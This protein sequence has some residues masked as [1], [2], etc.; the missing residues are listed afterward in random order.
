M[1][2]IIKSGVVKIKQHL[3]I[4]ING[5]KKLLQNDKVWTIIDLLK[6]LQLKQEGRI[7]EVNHTIIQQ[8]EYSEI[9]LKQGDEVEIIQFM[10]GGS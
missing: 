9:V 4:I 8:Q 5:E 3:N 7:I 1:V 6:W 2:A 10:G